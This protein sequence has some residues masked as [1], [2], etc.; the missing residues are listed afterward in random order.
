LA[1]SL[2]FTANLLLMRAL[3]ATDAARDREGR[4]KRLSVKSFIE[5]ASVLLLMVGFATL[6]TFSLWTAWG[7]A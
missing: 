6:G 2:L 1:S 3:G 5:F 4:F 7:V